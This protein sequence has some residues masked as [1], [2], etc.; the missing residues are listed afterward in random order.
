MDSIHLIAVL[1]AGL[2][3]SIIGM[4]WFSPWA[5]GKAWMRMVTIAPDRVPGKK[6]MLGSAVI[7][8]VFNIILAYVLL[9]F[10]RAWGVF[11]WVS[12]I[13]LA[14][15]IWLGF[16]VPVIVNTILWERKPWKWLAIN[17]GYYF[18]SLA[19]MALVI[20]FVSGFAASF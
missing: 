2:L 9:Y 16:M 19:L 4:T 20:L 7:G 15:W 3:G 14:F 12:A 17:G 8:T 13:E 11:D 6:G 18:V 5:F 10:G 1:I